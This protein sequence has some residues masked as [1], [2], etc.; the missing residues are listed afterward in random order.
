MGTTI[1]LWESLKSP[2]WLIPKV[3]QPHRDHTATR[4]FVFTERDKTPEVLNSK[5]ITLHAHGIH[6]RTCRAELAY[7]QPAGK[8]SPSRPLYY[9]YNSEESGKYK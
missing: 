9:L 4:I 6:L 2:R 5:L 7:K 3:A 8:Q 1:Y